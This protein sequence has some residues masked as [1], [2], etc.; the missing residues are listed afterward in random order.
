MARNE[1]EV[2]FG[3]FKQ[4]HTD[5]SIELSLKQAEFFKHQDLDQVD[6]IGELIKQEIGRLRFLQ[7]YTAQVAGTLKD[8]GIHMLEEIDEARKAPAPLVA[9]KVLTPEAEIKDEELIP[10]TLTTPDGV[11]IGGYSGKLLSFLAHGGKFKDNTSAALHV[12]GK[13][14]KTAARQVA[15]LITYLKKEESAASKHGVRIETEKASP[16][17]RRQG[18][19]DKHR[20]VF[21]PLHSIYCT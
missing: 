2:F 14:D 3:I 9:G 6:A 13:D 12:Y 11:E 15:S 7:E 20:V 5:K 18:A 10:L 17:E 4:R 1:V 21:T 19:R 8:H 16:K